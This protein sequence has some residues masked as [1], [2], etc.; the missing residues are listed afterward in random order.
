[1]YVLFLIPDIGTSASL[2]D[3]N[4]VAEVCLTASVRTVGHVT[5][6]FRLLALSNLYSTSGEKPSEVCVFY[7]SHILIRGRSEKS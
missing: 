1:M 7:V 5:L 3:N 6:T 2:A 4:D